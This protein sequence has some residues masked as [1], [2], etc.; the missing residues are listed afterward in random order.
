MIKIFRANMFRLSKSRLF[1]WLVILTALITA[2]CVLLECMTIEGDISE[3]SLEKT[4][5]SGAPFAQIAAAA[6]TVL[7]LGADNGNNTVRNKLIVGSRRRDVYSAVVIALTAAFALIFTTGTVYRRLNHQKEEMRAVYE[8][9]ELTLETAENP[10]YVGGFRR[11]AYELALHTSPFG[12]TI[13]LSNCDLKDPAADLAGAAFV[14]I[15]V[16]LLGE[17]RF[18]RIDLK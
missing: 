3:Y 1:W 8:N 5:L 10:Y 13:A 4:A 15:F 9:G 18:G 14:T 2:G 12:P 16:S 7:F 6:V 17:A 11:T